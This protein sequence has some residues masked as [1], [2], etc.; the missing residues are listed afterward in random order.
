MAQTLYLGL[1]CRP[2][3]REDDPIKTNRPTAKRNLKVTRVCG[4]LLN[5]NFNRLWANA[6]NCRA[7]SGV[8][9]FAMLHDDIT[10]D[11]DWC[12]TLLEELDDTG[13]DVLSVVIP[14]K[15][16][17]GLTST[18]IRNAITGDIR[19]LTMR[20]V[21]RLPETFGLADALAAGINTGGDETFLVNTGMW[22]ARLDRP[23]AETFPGFRSIDQI[24]RNGAGRWEAV[25]LP[26]D[27]CFSAW[28]A[29]LGL[30]VLATRKAAAIHHGADGDYRND[31]PWGTCET[32]PGDAPKT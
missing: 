14:L 20:E 31:E 30:K 28:A 8:T 1:P 27:W 15:D 19:R 21:H 12:D 7:E 18:G 9:R 16:K 11:L 23:W 25:S 3:I 17:R 32:D 29:L 13:A 2:G 4:S 6:L 5:L 22:V 10:P 26:E 24:R